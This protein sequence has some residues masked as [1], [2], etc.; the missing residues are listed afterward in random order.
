LRK[1]IPNQNG[2]SQF[3]EGST[4]LSCEECRL[5]LFTRKAISLTTIG[6]NHL[7]TAPST[8]KYMLF[9][10]LNLIRISRNAA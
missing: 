6:S 5:V 10:T 4:V 7:P 3:I 2:G 9:A 1:E 8:T